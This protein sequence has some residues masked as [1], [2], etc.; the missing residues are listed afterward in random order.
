MKSRRCNLKE[1]KIK[2]KRLS[3][4]KMKAIFLKDCCACPVCDHPMIPGHD[5]YWLCP[6]K[7]HTGLIENQRLCSSFVEKMKNKYH[8][9]EDH[10]LLFRAD[11]IAKYTHRICGRMPIQDRLVAMMIDIDKVRSRPKKAE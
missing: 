11:R 2:K 10:V 7:G 4:A 6:V 5:L 8:A 1:K 3:I 9:F